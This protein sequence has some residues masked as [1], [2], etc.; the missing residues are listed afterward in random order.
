MKARVQISSGYLSRLCG[1]HMKLCISQVHTT[2]LLYT[3][4]LLTHEHTHIHLIILL[5]LIKEGGIHRF[6]HKRI[7]EK[8]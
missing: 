5:I 1:L 8:T 2:T 7:C 3:G 6:P 4:T